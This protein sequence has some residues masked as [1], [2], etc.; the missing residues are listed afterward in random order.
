MRFLSKQQQEVCSLPRT[1]IE[2]FSWLRCA[3]YIAFVG[4]LS[5]ITEDFF[6]VGIVREY[7]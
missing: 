4:C 3:K 1:K 2:I 5:E 7:H 6:S